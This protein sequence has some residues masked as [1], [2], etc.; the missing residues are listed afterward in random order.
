MK[1]LRTALLLLIVLT[2]QAGIAQ[3]GLEYTGKR[4]HLSSAK[5]LS[6][7]KKHLKLKFVVSNTGREDVRLYEDLNMSSVIFTFGESFDDDRIARFKDLILDRL[8][9]ENTLLRAGQ[10]FTPKAYKIK[11]NSKV[12]NPRA[13]DFDISK[14]Q[15]ADLESYE[16]EVPEKKETVRNPREIAHKKTPKKSKKPDK[17]LSPIG[18]L[19]RPE[20]SHECFDLVIDNME[21]T[22]STK[23]NI[24]LK[25]NLINYGQGGFTFDRKNPRYENL[26]V[27]V[28]FA[29]IP[30]LTRGS[31]IAGGAHFDEIFDE[32]RF[33]LAFGESMEG[34]IKVSLEKMTKFTPVVILELDPFSAVDECDKVNNVST[35]VW[36]N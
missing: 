21:I 27:K 4:I 32:K 9:K 5:V 22:K 29:S 24:Y 18:E 25:F 13:K 10:L 8:I 33:T 12:T 7:T 36:K 19:P 26:S 17:V 3:N 30:R 15:T 28:Y 31:L 35:V 16:K 11:K 34:H 20:A 2:W 23:R 6:D 14:S 1:F